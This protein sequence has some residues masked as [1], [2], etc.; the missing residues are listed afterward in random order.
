MV[1]R[2]PGDATGKVNSLSQQVHRPS[3]AGLSNSEDKQE[4]VGFKKETGFQSRKPDLA[5]L[6]RP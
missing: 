1:I 3:P 5:Q 6:F 4:E 2:K